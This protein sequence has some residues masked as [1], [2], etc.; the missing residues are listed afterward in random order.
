VL[1]HTCFHFCFTLLL[2]AKTAAVAQGAGRT[3]DQSSRSAFINNIITL[4][5][6]LILHLQALLVVT[7]SWHSRTNSTCC[8][9]DSL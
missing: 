3:A 4:P 8:H 7:L 9:E 1:K 2:P 6:S 5:A